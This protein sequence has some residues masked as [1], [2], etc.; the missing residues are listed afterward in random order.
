MTHS[1]PVS[2]SVVKAHF[3]NHVSPGKVDFFESAGID[4]VIGDRQGP[5][6]WDLAGGKKLINCHCNGG[7]F[8]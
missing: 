4:F 7:V 3:R 1:G 2:K 8:N 5:F 6:I